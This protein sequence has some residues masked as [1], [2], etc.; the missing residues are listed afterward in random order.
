MM[1]PM[2]QMYQQDQYPPIKN[3]QYPP[4][5]KNEQYAPSI[6]P[7]QFASHKTDSFQNSQQFA[8][9]Q[10]PYPPPSYSQSSLHGSIPPLQ[11]QN[12]NPPPPQYPQQFP[13]QSYPQMNILQRISNIIK[14][15]LPSLQS[16]VQFVNRS[17]MAAV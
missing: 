15:Q 8:P 5:L 7:D 13:T 3:D 17:S 16:I 4:S 6:K 1:P 10:S 11:Q 9:S 12:L 14:A 2:Q